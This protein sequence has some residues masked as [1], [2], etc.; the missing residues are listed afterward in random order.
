MR[1]DYM[2]GIDATYQIYRTNRHKYSTKDAWLE[3]KPCKP[4]HILLDKAVGIYY[5]GFFISHRSLFDG[6]IYNMD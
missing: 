4:A 6:S 1:P 3:L 5:L 2:I